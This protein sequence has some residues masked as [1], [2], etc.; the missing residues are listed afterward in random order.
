M[1]TEKKTMYS[2]NRRP[3]KQKALKSMQARESSQWFLM[4]GD[5]NPSDLLTDHPKISADL[6]VHGKDVLLSASDALKPEDFGGPHPGSTLQEDGL[7]SSLR[8]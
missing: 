8:D 1:I 4:K 5:E 6:G 3:S 2:T 7:E